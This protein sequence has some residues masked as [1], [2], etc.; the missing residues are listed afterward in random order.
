MTH[1]EEH[2][3]NDTSLPPNPNIAN[4]MFIGG[5]IEHWGRGLSLMN[6]ECD[7]VGLPK[8]RIIDNGFIIK[9]IFKRPYILTDHILKT[10]NMQAENQKDTVN[11]E[12]DT[13]STEK[14]T[15]DVK[16]DILSPENQQRLKAGITKIGYKLGPNWKP[17]GKRE[18]QALK[19]IN[20]IGEDWY[21]ATEL[22]D[23]LGH[24]SKNTFLRNYINPMLEDG[25]LVKDK[26]E[27]TNAPNQ[28]YGLT[29]KGKAIYY[30]EN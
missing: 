22:C 2:N 12:K 11:A 16:K 17:A 14:D 1:E 4:V 15:A 25:L 30:S 7:R 9:V 29:V 27:S 8:P 24:K 23:L 10:R 6:D 28:R 18:K 20:I 26:A 5:L 3:D 19:I 13:V 21:S